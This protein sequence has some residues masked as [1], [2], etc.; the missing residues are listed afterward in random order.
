M[1]VDKFNSN[2]NLYVDI[3]QIK[4]DYH[5]DI[6]IMAKV[7]EDSFSDHFLGHMGHKFLGLFISEFVNTAGN[8]GYVAKFK[9][10]PIGFILATR[11]DNPF[12]KFYR[13]RFLSVVL[14][15]VARYFKDPFIRKHIGER[16]GLI[17]NALKALFSKENT[18]NPRQDEKVRILVPPRLLAIAVNDKFRGLGVANELTR[19]FCA[20]M[21]TKGFKKVALSAL[22]WNRRAIGFYKKDG[23]IE[24]NC[25]ESSIGFYRPI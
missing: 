22:P 23:W 9:E 4:F 12:N 7:Y 19:Q 2:N 1:S 21:R 13:K 8:Y 17:N 14:I 18:E 5:D 3:K 10:E 16:L 11:L 6:R 25:S 20:E 24:E 15:T